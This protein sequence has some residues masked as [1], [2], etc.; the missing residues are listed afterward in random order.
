MLRNVQIHVAFQVNGTGQESACGNY[1]APTSGGVA[2]SDRTVN[3]DCIFLSAVARRA[4]LGNVEIARREFGSYHARG[5]HSQR[6]L[7]K[8]LPPSH[9]FFSA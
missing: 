5:A 9:E 8:P 3:S 6:G 2:G 7:M 4:E 1:H